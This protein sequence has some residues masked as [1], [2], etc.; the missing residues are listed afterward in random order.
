MDVDPTKNVVAF[1]VEGG[2]PYV[3]DGP[4]RDDDC[5]QKIWS[6]APFMLKFSARKVLR[7]H[8]EWQPSSA[9]ADFIR[10]TFPMAELTYTFTRP[11]PNGWDAAFAEARR[12]IVREHSKDAM[13]QVAGRGELLPILWSQGSPI[14]ET[15]SLLPYRTLIEGKLH[16]ALATVAMAQDG[17]IGMNHIALGG[18]EDRAFDEVLEEAFGELT[19]GLKVEGLADPARSG[20]MAMMQRQGPFASSAIALPNFHE[21]LSSMLGN[22]HL[23]VGLPDPDTVLVTPTNSGWVDELQRL[24][25]NSPDTAREFVP[26][27]LAFEPNGLRFVAERQ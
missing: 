1:D 12:A 24:V 8:S 4:T 9:D 10:R 17:R 19:R 7:I 3:S 14:I 5:V 25:L 18:L 23:L 16:V 2:E 21:Q 15:L 20:E 22:D 13:E 27:V 11:G 6:R 26:S